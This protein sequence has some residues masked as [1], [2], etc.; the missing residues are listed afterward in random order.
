MVRL[1][2]LPAVDAKHLLSKPCEP[3]ASEPFV[4]GP[5][6]RQRRVAL[7]TTAGLHSGDQQNF[8]LRDVGYRVI[9]GDIAGKD[10]LMSHTSVNFDRAGFQQ[11]VNIVFPIDRLRE[12]AANGEIGSVADFNYSVMGAG[13]EP[14]EIEPTAR[15]I[16]GQLTMDNVDA[17][18]LIPV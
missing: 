6:V 1:S 5:P 3:F 17:A 18:V 2:D 16:A 7:V 14:E 10:L 13:W 12:I 4:R 15:E 9:P 11:D 8:A